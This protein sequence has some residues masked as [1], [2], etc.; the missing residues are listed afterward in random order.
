MVRAGSERKSL[1]AVAIIAAMSPS[2]LGNQMFAIL[3]EMAAESSADGRPCGLRGWAEHYRKFASLKY[4]KN[5]W[6]T[7]ITATL[8]QRLWCAGYPAFAEPEYPHAAWSSAC[9]PR[10]D[11]VIQVGK[12]QF[13]WVEC[14]T[15][16][17]DYFPR[18]EAPYEFDYAGTRMLH[19]DGLKGVR[20]LNS[21]V[22][23]LESLRR[24]EAT[25]KGLL[26]VAF[27]YPR[28]LLTDDLLARNLPSSLSDWSAAHATIAGETWADAPRASLGFR[29]RCWFWYQ[30]I[31]G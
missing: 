20:S 27:D 28:Q 21:D 4:T 13:M 19:C 8:V 1:S 12:D 7:V 31:G 26:L 23:K 15:A 18:T 11:L 9:K 16:Y 25:H 3:R 17:C 22:M 24:P 2:D 6:E 10:C 30:S 5:D 14:K 29:D